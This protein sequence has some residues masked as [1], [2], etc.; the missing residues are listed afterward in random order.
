LNAV[1]VLAVSQTNVHN[2]CVF[3]HIRLNAVPVL[4]VSQTVADFLVFGD[5]I[6]WVLYLYWQ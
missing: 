3:V 2:F 5:I 1:P 4:A 6:V